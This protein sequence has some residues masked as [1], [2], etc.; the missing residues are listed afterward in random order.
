MARFFGELGACVID[1]DKLAHKALTKTSPFYP[2]IAKRFPEACDTEGK[3]NRKKLARLVFSNSRRRK[4]LETLTHPYVF[5]QI[6]HKVDSAREA[7]VA[8]EV[9]LLYESGF[10]RL[11]HKTVA[12][13]TPAT[14]VAE[15]LKGKGYAW[16]EIEARQKA[17]LPA[18]EKEKRSDFIVH[19]AGNYQQTRREVKKI[20]KSIRPVFQKE[21]MKDNG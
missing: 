1:A 7:V 13:S 10:D 21:I 2:R 9:P 3:V 11:C 8:I 18:K 14:R 16:E 20:W 6:R 4:E 12:V 5:D 19:N 17:Q 15:R